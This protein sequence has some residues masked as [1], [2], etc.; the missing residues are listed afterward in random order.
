MSDVISPSTFNRYR[1]ENGMLSFIG[2]DSYANLMQYGITSGD[3]EDAYFAAEFLCGKMR[4]FVLLS[5]E[6]NIMRGLVDEDV[7]ANKSAW[8]SISFGVYCYEPHLLG[9][10]CLA[11]PSA[12]FGVVPYEWDDLKVIGRLVNTEPAA[13]TVFPLQ[14]ERKN[15]IGLDLQYFTANLE[16]FPDTMIVH[17]SKCVDGGND[18]FCLLYSAPYDDGFSERFIVKEESEDC[19]VCL[20]TSEFAEECFGTLP[21]SYRMSAGCSFPVEIHP[22]EQFVSKTGCK[23]DSVN[24]LISGNHNEFLNKF[25]GM[26]N[27]VSKRQWCWSKRNSTQTRCNVFKADGFGFCDIDKLEIWRKRFGTQRA[28]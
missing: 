7:Q 16:K 19:D 9:E 28:L 13:P 6:L 12:R 1:V 14:F 8:N 22:T 20:V 21:L 4:N 24:V 27:F 17:M 10:I 11:R 2:R 25:M 23:R 5:P 3:D 18:A 26:Y 15:G